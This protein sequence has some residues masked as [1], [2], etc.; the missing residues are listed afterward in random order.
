MPSDRARYS[1]DDLRPYRNVIPQQGRVTL[2]ADLNEQNELATD[3][4]RQALLDVIGPTGTPNDGFLITSTGSFDFSIGAGD[5]YLGGVRVQNPAD[6]PYSNQTEW[7]D[8]ASD[9]DWIAPNAQAGGG[10]PNEIVYLEVFEQDVSAVEDQALREPAL[11]GPDSSDRLSILRRVKRHGTSADNCDDAFNEMIDLWKG[12]GLSFDTTTMALSSST[13][14]LVGFD[15]VGGGGDCEP[16]PTGGYLEADNQLIR[17]MVAKPDDKG[18]LQLLWG[19]NNASDLYRVS[20]HP[21]LM[22]LDVSPPPVDEYHMLTHGQAVEVLRSAAQLD[23]HDNWVAEAMGEIN[24]IDTPYQ[25][26]Q[27][28][29]QSV[30][31]A[32]LAGAPDQV[33]VRVWEE[34]KTFVSGTPVVL[35][36]TGIQVTLHA[37]AAGIHPGDFWCFAVRP[38]VATAVAAAA[39]TQVLPRRYTDSPQLPEGPRVWACPLA[40]L[41]VNDAKTGFDPKLL[42]D[43]RKHFD[44]LVILTG[45]PTGNAGCTIVVGPEDL[46]GDQAL[47][48]LIQAHHDTPVTIS[49]LPA[50]YTLNAPLKLVVGNSDVTLESCPPGAILAPDSVTNP[51]F[52]QGLVI[53]EGANRVTFRDLTFQMPS[54]PTTVSFPYLGGVIAGGREVTFPLDASIAIRAV[55]CADLVVANCTFRY[56]L[57][58]KSQTN[59]VGNGYAAAIA[60]SGTCSRHMVTGNTFVLTERYERTKTQPFRAIYGYTLSSVVEPPVGAGKKFPIL[61]GALLGGTFDGN[62]FSGLS[63]AVVVNADCN[64]IV[65][66]ANRVMQCDN[67]FSFKARRAYVYALEHGVTQPTPDVVETAVNSKVQSVVSAA[68]LQTFDVLGMIFP[69]PDGYDGGQSVTPEMPTKSQATNAGK[70]M[71]A[72]FSGSAAGRSS[73]PAGE[74]PAGARGSGRA[75]RATKATSG[76]VAGE[77]EAAGLALNQIGLISLIQLPPPYLT[78]SVTDNE[79][80]LRILLAETGVGLVVWDDQRETSS[81]LVVQGNI[82][83]SLSSTSPTALIAMVERCTVTGNVIINEIPEGGMS[84]DLWPGVN[85]GTTPGVAVTGNIFRGTTD[86]P[87]RP[88]AAPMNDWLVLNTAL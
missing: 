34:V 38:G 30:V 73:I 25:Q 35:G 1:L 46:K 66:N 83:R 26:G 88:L 48:K 50:T 65:L 28:K 55:G 20:V 72:R 60:A 62:S 53:L 5:I 68:G 13:T 23:N 19:F 85:T 41:K 76:S 56:R 87:P 29:L 54:V 81:S 17:V 33:F 39:A 10:D 27:V 59:P 51:N 42:A 11:G 22:T 4:E 49:L 75:L 61:P 84:L 45:R 7:V 63:G 70:Q 37:P 14:L 82:I 31:A 64:D 86:L 2:E 21:D 67:G 47:L 16:A 58:G 69:L 43:C 78:M 77:L 40:L 44:N 32:D 6:Y 8:S 3:A 24:L 15:A 52:A 79:I 9:P 18:N 74:A 71:V 36:N 80:D 12:R 57:P